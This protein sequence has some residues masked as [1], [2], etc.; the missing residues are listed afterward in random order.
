[1]YFLFLYC[2]IYI[3]GVH[4]YQCRLKKEMEFKIYLIYRW[5]WKVLS[6]K[7]RNF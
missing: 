1:V 7:I 2:D 3:I 4:I 6:G 5:V